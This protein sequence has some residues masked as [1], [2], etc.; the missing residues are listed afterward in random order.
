MKDFAVRQL[1]VR[2]NPQRT[3]ETANAWSGD[4]W[5]RSNTPLKYPSTHQ[6]SIALGSS[7]RSIKLPASVCV[8]GKRSAVLQLIINKINSFYPLS[9]SDKGHVSDARVNFPAQKRKLQIC[10]HQ[11]INAF[12]TP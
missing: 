12:S 11:A 6:V 2:L 7:H 4:S 5:A 3:I 10:R 1:Y 9:V 8:L